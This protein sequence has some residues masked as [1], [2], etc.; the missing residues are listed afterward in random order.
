MAWELADRLANKQAGYLAQG[1]AGRLANR[2]PGKSL[3]SHLRDYSMKCD[4]PLNPQT[5]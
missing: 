4:Y 3:E 5:D 1:L 2:Q